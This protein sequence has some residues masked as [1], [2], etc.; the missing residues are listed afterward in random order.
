MPSTRRR[1]AR[2]GPR[3]RAAPDSVSPMEPWLAARPPDEF[4]AKAPDAADVAG[5]DVWIVHPWS[6]GELPAALP[7]GTRVIG[8]FVDDFHRS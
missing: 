1:P 7:E 8:V 2:Q 5:R 6:L 3:E 4:G